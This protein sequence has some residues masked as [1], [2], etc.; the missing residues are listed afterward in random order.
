M[1]GIGGA[2]R[3]AKAR[4]QEFSLEAMEPRLLLSADTTLISTEIQQ[5]TTDGLTSLLGFADTIAAA[6]ALQVKIPGID[7]SLSDIIDLRATLED[8]LVQPVL[9]Y[10]NTHS[11]PNTTFGGLSNALSPFVTLQ[12]WD[13][14]TGDYQFKLDLNAAATTL[15]YN[16]GDNDPGGF[17]LQVNGALGLGVEL[18][19]LV[20]GVKLS[21]GGPGFY[22]GTDPLQ[23]TAEA[24]SNNLD[25][26][27]HLGFLSVGVE[28][29]TIDLNAA[30]QVNLTGLDSNHD[31]M[32]TPAEISANVSPLDVQR[33]G[34][35]DAGSLPI[36]VAL[37]GV[38]SAAGTV[39]LG[40]TDVFDADTYSFDYSGIDQDALNF[41]NIDAAGVV[42]LIG[43][44]S[45]ELNNLR[46]SDFFDQIN[47]PL[48]DGSIGEVLDF[49]GVVSRTLLYDNGAD[50]VK[51]GANR[52]ASDLNAALGTAGLDT[53]IVV[54]G[55]GTSLT[56]QIID[57]TVTSFKIEQVAGN[58]TEL[59]FVLNDAD[60]LATV[61][62][63]TPTDGVIAGDVKMRFTLMR[64]AVSEAVEVTVA[65]D[66]T[67]GN[68]GIG[69]DTI[70]LLRADNS[71]TFDTIQELAFRLNTILGAGSSVVYDP[72]S[73]ALTINLGA[74]LPR[75]DFD[76]DLPIAF[77]F[78]LGPLL[79]I[80]SNTLVNVN[81]SIGFADGFTLGF[82]LGDTVPGAQAGLSTGTPL[83]GLNDGDGVDIK[84]AP[85]LTAPSAVIS[86]MRPLSGDA[87]FEI[88]LGNEASGAA[89]AISAAGT[90]LT[91][92]APGHSFTGKVSVGDTVFNI[93]DG[94][95]AKVISITATTITTGA[96][97][98]G[99]E[100]DWDV[101]D[102]YRT[103]HVVTVG[104]GDTQV[105]DLVDTINEAIDS[106]AALNGR[107]EAVAN[108]NRLSLEAV[109]IAVVGFGF[110]AAQADP[111]VK[112][113]GFYA[114]RGST[115][116]LVG[117]S[118]DTFV[119][120]AGDAHFT[121]T[122][123]GTDYHVTVLQ[124]ATV[125][126]TTIGNLAADVN[127]ALLAAGVGTKVA[128]G[129][130]GT[131]LVLRITD[132]SVDD[133]AFT[134]AI[135]DPAVL[136]LGLTNATTITQ[137]RLGAAKDLTQ[138][139]GRLP[140]DAT[141]TITTTGGL[142]GT[143][144]LF[145]DDTA[146]NSTIL[147]VVSDL[148]KA[149]S[150]ATLKTGVLASF[151]PVGPISFDVAVNGAAP[152]TV[153]LGASALTGNANLSDLVED[154]NAALEAA[155]LGGV[156]TA[157]SS[158]SDSALGHARV[159]FE[160]D[161]ATVLQ[162]QITASAG[163]GLALPT[164]ATATN[165]SGQLVA[166]SAGNKLVLSAVAG[167]GIT[168]FTVA[169]DTGAQA[170]GL[171]AGPQ[172]S[173]SDDIEIRVSNPT[174]AGQVIRVSLDGV[175][176]IAGVI[177]AI[178]TATAG[179]VQVEINEAQTGLTL[180]DTT[181]LANGPNARAFMV[182]A[183]NG[184]GAAAGLRIAG[185]DAI[186]E[187]Q[188][189]GK[190]DGGQLTGIKL[191]DRFF[192]RD[193][194]LVGSLEVSTPGGIDASG[195]VGFVGIN[196]A[197]DASLSADFSI[198]V[199]DPGT[200]AGADNSISLTEFTTGLSHVNTLLDAPSLTGLVQLHLDV[201]LDGSLPFI[202]LGAGTVDLAA[203]LGDA[204]AKWDDVVNL[205]GVT[206][207]PVDDTHFTLSGDL[208][209][210]F[211]R[212]A[213]VTVG[214]FETF[215]GGVSFSGGLT[216]VEVLDDL[217][218][219]LAGLSIGTPNAAISDFESD[220][221]NL[222]EF[223]NV[224]FD[225]DSIVDALLMVRNL[226]GEI[227]VADSLLSAPIPLVDV[228]VSDLLDFADTFSHA[229][230][231]AQHNPAASLQLL[232]KTISEAFG[233]DPAGDLI[234][235]TLDDFGTPGNVDDDVI[236]IELNLG[237]AFGRSLS[238]RIPDLDLPTGVVD[239]GGAATLDAHGSANF[240]L[241]IGIGLNDPSMLY[242]YDSSGLQANL[243]LSGSDM[244]FKA[245]LGP[246]SL[247]V[248]GGSAS[249][250]GTVNASFAAGHFTNGRSLVQ[251]LADLQSLLGD[252]DVDFSAPVSATLPI[253]FPTET[254][255]VGDIT[256]TG[257]LQDLAN[258]L[259]LKTD[260]AAAPAD[261]IVLDVSDVL[262]DL[263]DGFQ[264]L[265]LL[266]QIMFIVDGVDVALG[267]VQDAMDGEMF[268]FTLPII[269]DKLGRAADVVGD[270][271]T[272]FLND[273][274][275][276][277][278]KLADPSENGIKDILFK[279]L[280][281]SGFLIA[282][283][284]DGNAL[285]D[286]DGKFVAGTEDDIQSYNNLGDVS[287]I[288]DAEIWWKVKIGQNL[289]DTGADIGFD[290]GI[291][292]LGLETDGEIK[293]NIDWEL[294]LGFGL[295]GKDGFFFFLDDGHGNPELQLRASVTLPD[296]SLKGTLGFL[297]FT[298]ENKDVDGDG[299]E[300]HLTANFGIDIVN[301][302]DPNDTR[303]GLSELGRM[304]F[305]V[306]F[307]ADASAELGM[308]LGIAGDDG[309]FP[310]LKADFLFD[311]GID[312]INLFDPGDNF[313]FGSAIMDGL[314]VVEFKNVGL[315]VG[316]Y[317][318]NV[319]EPLVEKIQDVTE[320]VQ[321][322]I[323]IVTTP[324]PV[325]SDLGLDIT[326][327][328]IAKASGSVDPRFIDAV[329]TIFDI[330]SMLNSIDLS[331]G[332]SL[333][334]PFGDFTVYDSS[335]PLFANFGGNLGSVDFDL[336]GFAASVLDPNGPLHGLISGLPA[337]LQEVLGEAGGVAAEILGGMAQGAGGGTSDPFK[338]DILED[339]S[340]VFG[341]LMGKPATLISYDM[342]KLSF[343]AEF[344][345]FFSIFGPLGV[346]INLEANLNIDFAFG[347]DTQGFIDFAASDFKN[348]LLLANGLFINDDPTPSDPSDG[349]D[350]P[351]LTF[352]GGLWAAAELNLGIARGG[353]GGGIFIDVDFNLFDNDGD[354][355]IRLDELAT[356][357]SN[358]LKAPDVA[359]RFLAPL[360]IF[361]VSGKVTAELFA[362]LK[363]DFGFFELD[364]K[365]QITPP[366]VLADF[367]V[368]FFRPPV[369]ASEL[370]N[371]DLIINIGDFAG[372]RKLGDLSDFGEHITVEA[373]ADPNVVAIWSDNLE[374]AG[375]DAKQYYH[376]TGKI[377]AI[378]GKGDDIID[379]SGVGSSI[380]Y[381]IDGGIGSD[382]IHGS[383]GGG[384]MRGG[385]GDDFLYGGDGA[386]L[387]L[388]NEGGDT[389]AGGKG[390]DI[391][392]GDNGEITDGLIDMATRHGFVRALVSLTDG[393]DTIQGNEGDDIIAGSGAADTLLDGGADNDVVVGDGALFTYNSPV[394]VSGTESGQGYA[395]VLISGG[396]GNDWLYGGKGDDTIHGDSGDD[397]VFGG[398]GKDAIDGGADK[399]TLFG[400]FGTFI[401]GDLAKPV[402]TVGGDADTI[403]GGLGNDN[404]LGGGGNDVMHGD[405]DNDV[406]WG[407]T[408]AD[409][410]YGDA[411][412]DTIL[413][414]SDQDK[415]YGGSG[416][417]ILEGG[418]GND[419]LFGGD[420]VVGKHDGVA[421]ASDG[422]DTLVAGYGSDV[423]D[424]EAD[425]DFYLINARGGNTTELT[426][427]YDS[428]GGTSDSDLL[429]VTGTGEADVFLLRA[430]SDSYF[431]LE[432]KL[433]AALDKAFIKADL[434]DT[435]L[436]KHELFKDAITA[437]YGPHQAPAT[438]LAALDA[439]NLTTGPGYTKTDVL[440]ALKLAVSS[441]Y[442]SELTALGA[443]HNT[444]FVA[445]LNNGGA[446]VERFNYRS[447]EG[448]V[449]NTVGGDDYVVC[450]DVLGATTINLGTGNDRIQIGQVFHSERIVDNPI[451]GLTT[452]IAPDDVFATIAITRGWLSNGVSVATTVNGGDGNDE[453]TV[454]HNIGALN[455]NGGEG[456]DLF[457]VRAFALAGST[458]SERG[459]TDMKGDAGAD[460]IL[461]AVNAPVG[462]DGGDGFDTVRVIGTEFSD[463]FVVTD[464]G[465]FGAGLNISYVNIEK[466][467]ADG[468]EGNDRFFVLSTGIGVI[469]ELDGGL[470]SDSFFVG[471]SPSD[472][473]IPVISDDLKG[474]SG[475]V[476]HSVESGDLSYAGLA[477][478]GVSA[479]VADNEKD[480]IVVSE[481]GGVSRV[482]E[483]ATSGGEGWQ[484][485]SY[486]V[487]LTRAPDPGTVVKINVVQAALPP[488]DEAKGYRY[489]EFY[490]PANPSN[491]LLDAAGNPIGPVLTFDATNWFTPQTVKFRAAQDVG[492][493]GTAYTFINHTMSDETT[494]PLYADAKVLSVKVQIND[495]DRAGVII[496]PTNRNNTVLEGGFGDTYQVVLTRAPTDDVT[497]HL[498]TINNQVS[499][500]ATTLTFSADPSAPNAWNKPQTVTITAI[501]DNVLE[502]FH[503]DYISYS[504]TSEHDV[505]QYLQQPLY[506]IDG[507]LLTDVFGDGLADDFAPTKPV[508]YMFLAARPVQNDAAKPI[509]I[510]YDADGDLGAGTAVELQ[511]YHGETDGELRYAITGNTLEFYR[512]G[513]AAS[514]SGAI[515]AGYYYLKPGYDQLV[516]QDSVVDI[517]DNDAP[518]VIVTQSD[519]STDVI[520]GG[521]TDSYT[522][523]LSK[524]PTASVTLTIDAVNTRTTLDGFA[525]FQEQV[526]V[527][528]DGFTWAS[529]VQVTFDNDSGQPDSWNAP[530][531]I[532]VRAIDD[533]VLDGDDT[534]VFAPEL[535]TVNKIRG[536]LIIEGAAGSGSL[537]LPAPLMLPGELNV[538]P[539][540]G[541]V[542]AFTPGSGEGAFEYMD[543]KTAELQ[544]LFGDLSKDFNNDGIADFNTFVD[545]ID[546]TLELT[547]GPGTGVVLDPSR[548]RD[549]FDRFWLIKAVDTIAGDPAHMRLKLQNPS[550]VDP[551]SPSVTAPSVLSKY[552]IT[553]LSPNFFADEREQVDFTTVF[554]EDSVADD[555]GRLTSADGNV[556]GYDAAANT[557]TV[558]TADLQALAKL[559][560]IPNLETGLVGRTLQVTVGPGLDRV[561]TIDGV[562]DGAAG[563]KIL[564]LTNVSGSGTPTDR[565]EYRIEGGDRKGR[566]TG[567][568]MGPNLIIGDG[569]Q[570]GGITY[571][572]MEVVQVNLGSGD[573]T[574]TVN[575]ATH[576]DDHT[577]K[578]NGDFYTLTMLNTGEG[579]DHVTVKLID[580]QAG[581]FSLDTGA[582]NDTVDGSASS[583]PLVIF[584]GAGDDTITGGSGADTLFGD[585]GRVDYLDDAGE[586][587]T[588]LGATVAQ[589]PVNP[590]VAHTVASATATTITDSAANYAVGA[591]VGST[592][593][594]VAS[595]GSA[596][597]RTIVSNTAT[598]ITVDS[599]WTIT[600]VNSSFY[601]V[602]FSAANVSIDGTPRA[603]L[604]DP[605][606]NFETGYGGLVGLIVQ[607][608]S[609]D[610]HVQYRQIIANT[611]TQLTLDKPWDTLPVVVDPS[612]PQLNYFYRVASYPEDQTD[613]TYRGPRVAWSIDTEVGGSDTL[614]GGA[615]AD[616]LI[617]GAGVDHVNGGADND[618]IA[619]DNARFDFDPV[620]G[621][622]GPTQVKLIQ[623]TAPG[624]GGDDVLS[625]DAGADII[626]GG[627]GADTIY[628][629]NA[630]GSN[631]ANDGADI[632]IG[633][634]GLIRFNGGYV[635]ADALGTTIDLIQTTDASFGG[636]DTIYG[637]N[638]NDILIGGTGDD[639]VSGDAGL[640]IILGDQGLF[641]LFGGKVTYV[642]DPG[643]AGDDF[644]T[645]GAGVDLI[646][647][648]LGNDRI[649]GLGGAD[650]LIGDEGEAFYAL[651]GVTIVGI[652]TLSL[653]P[654]SGGAD[655]IYGGSEDDIIIG[656]ANSD[657]LDGGDQKDLMFG[658]NVSLVLNAGSG[659]AIDPRFRAL[660]GTLIYGPD[661]L[662]QVAGA[663]VA[664]VQPVPGGR[665]AWGDWTITLDPTLVASRFGD[666]Y[667]AGGS[668]DDEIFGQL[669]NDTIQGDGTIGALSGL[670]PSTFVLPPMDFAL[671]A[672]GT[673]HVSAPTNVGA[674][675]ST[676]LTVQASFEGLN[677]GDDYIEGNGGSDVIF[678]NLGQDDIIGGN[679]SLFSLTTAALRPDGADLLFGGAGID[680]SRNNLGDASL[681]STGATIDTLPT[682]HSRDAD[683]ILGDNGNIF[684]LVGTNGVSSGNY[685]SFN[686]DNY[687]ALSGS[688]NKIIPRAAQLL[689]Y[690]PGGVS[691]DPA[692]ATDI[693]AADEIHGESGDDFIYGMTGSDVLFGEGQDDDLIGGW[694]FD[695]ISGGTGDDGVIGDD[696]R[697]LTSRNGLTEALAGVTVATTESVISTPGNV[698]VATIN[699]TGQ[700]LKAV[701]LTPFAKSLMDPL[702]DPLQADDVIYGGWGNDFLHGGWGDDAM[703]GAEALANFYSQPVNP[704]NVLNYDSATG[705]FALYDEYHPMSYID[706]FLLN[707]SA[708]EGPQLAGK[709]TVSTTDDFF[710]DGDD[711]IFGD[712]GNDWLVGG[713]G[714]DTTYGGWGDDLINADDNQ[715]TVG[716]LNLT[717]DTHA[718]YEDR[719]YGGAGRDVLIG[720]TGGD[721]LI[722]WVGEFNS[723]IVPFA[724]FGTA[725]VSRTL[726]PQLAEFLYALSK[727]D[728]ADQTLGSVGDVRNGEPWAELG[729]V[730]Q[731]DSAWQDQTGAP[732]DPQAGNVP[733]GKRDV[734]RSADFNTG[735]LQGFAADSGIW[736][737]SGGALQVASTS[738]KSDAVAIYQI[739]DALPS[740]YEVLATVKVIKPTG[741]WDANS[742]VVFD[743]QGATSFKYAGID[744]GTNKVVIGERTA[745]GWNVLAQGAITG[746]LKSDAWYNLSLSVNGL[747]ATL[748]VDNKTSL[749]YVFKPTVVDGYSYGLN[750]GLVGFGAN[751]SRGAIDNIAVQ[752][753][754][755]TATV[756][757][758]E[759]FT[760]GAGAMFDTQSSGTWST[761]AG[762][763][764]GAA[765]AGSD[766]ALNLIDL[767]NVT[768]LK[769]TSLLD[770]SAV[771]R[772]AGRAGLV[773]DYYSS[774][775]FKFAAIDVASKQVL[776]GHRTSAGWFIDAAASQSLNATTDYTLG[777]S[778]R[779]SSVSVTINGQAS[780]GFVFNA[781]AADGR[782]GLFTKGATAS[783]DS[784]T[785]KTNDS[786]VPAAQVTTA[787]SATA[788]GVAASLSNEQLLTL[789]AEAVRR[790]ASVEDASLLT[791]L[792]GLEFAVAD[793]PGDQL[794]EF[795]DGKI[796]VDVDAG[797]Y[798]WFVD[799][800]PGDDSEFSGH[801]A[802]LTAKPTG[803][804]AGRIDLL[805]VLAHEIGHA[806][807]F[808]HSESGVMDEERMPGERAL[809]DGWFAA[810]LPSEVIVSD[811]GNSRRET[812]A[813]KLTEL[814]SQIDFAPGL[815]RALNADAASSA[816]TPTTGLVAG[817]PISVPAR[818]PVGQ[819]AGVKAEPSTPHGFDASFVHLASPLA[820]SLDSATV[821]ASSEQASQSVGDEKDTYGNHQARSSSVPVPKS[822]TPV[823]DWQVTSSG[824]LDQRSTASKATSEWL[825]DFLN[826][827]GRTEVQR[828]PN[829]GI[830][831]RPISTG[832]MG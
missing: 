518:T 142:S 53:A 504:V 450:D 201:S 648:G 87:T 425:G 350:P 649:S 27:T 823:I 501:D 502:G 480:F 58:L 597:L 583:L 380:K 328:D 353:V 261:T 404:L 382:T 93:T 407:G 591:L 346:S 817:A 685:L 717:P 257:D 575:Y 408:G 383:N 340:Q 302:D 271:R 822:D 688:T 555:T 476:L 60:D 247:S 668:G 102:Q 83:T 827:L 25:F 599:N 639:N 671:A 349:E 316:S 210:K 721:R 139:V 291:P 627:Q 164:S 485:D 282:V 154:I 167:S 549:L 394:A 831:V 603:V 156:V 612:K 357:F 825:D 393:A 279:L 623:T 337:G 734:L 828:S 526:Q 11:D 379:L 20:F 10:F 683:T 499:L 202:T 814:V 234:S 396:S 733:G 313:E 280:G 699:V 681:N 442:V 600:P 336:S 563:T 820:R 810:G 745:A 23:V 646:I 213:R 290:I 285:K 593:Q 150:V 644:L 253:Y 112:D 266:D 367:D 103:A 47:L 448:L 611:A 530:Q 24:Q 239:F 658:D 617:G 355:K 596:Q 521:L 440:A 570:P 776:I 471:G 330:I 697:I 793:L 800:T 85:A 465:V 117:D 498:T 113:L 568:G 819:A 86:T 670:I 263:T 416:N 560:A 208:T 491:I 13:D 726:Q 55:D 707:F 401:D 713:T 808:G 638:G 546:K 352:D 333:L 702:F 515:R 722:D 12:T 8:N 161:P 169:G 2:G 177:L 310:Q 323:D 238:V 104:K 525:R 275:A 410:L 460:T 754:P 415:L 361:D 429:T 774:T 484:Y 136:E 191:S 628:G 413:G 696:G 59:G 250:A 312:P 188:R 457:T 66:S 176:D 523:Q 19:S 557:M 693:G 531:T 806:I 100:N 613:G 42:T 604:T 635:G 232:D 244:A 624:T 223:D 614:N 132:A 322:I 656:G 251:D 566:I 536:P 82:Y 803:E 520:E 573:D 508:S 127:A 196:L 122:I 88:V 319:V 119:L 300:T 304:G 551:A 675:R 369:L 70:K 655:A 561:W 576:S 344:S 358:Q 594:V 772:T 622:D 36:S 343:E 565:S 64:G 403:F 524:Q 365:F 581:A 315:D 317:I 268:G 760:T 727:S 607:A 771:L 356:N 44:L 277:V 68:T 212:G 78:D 729:V 786:A 46:S 189:D 96:L 225:F 516:V 572:D 487:R 218:V 418:H 461:Y 348:P 602:L 633:D 3:P 162:L 9:D 84:T 652:D 65:A 780:V 5:A 813:I 90:L 231:E 235:F 168:G 490:D 199:N 432:A 647:G 643:T 372:E 773:F 360:A 704:G 229:L 620:S 782:F 775:D 173:D 654:G 178:E 578:R 750:W 763:L 640:D 712:H 131:S 278:E 483:G 368:D 500:S 698:Q 678:G 554:D 826:H 62:T 179:Q 455:L 758:R 547:Q 373:T 695:W 17:G 630:A 629:D 784:V 399:D 797:G 260:A 22:L 31:Q 157:K 674:S 493:E 192:M 211:V 226:L 123:G 540:D 544:S 114:T 541:D 659:D 366:A 126:N 18:P 832:A 798:G 625:G 731:Q 796:T 281:D 472:A 433:T 144:T 206:V 509:V 303:L 108:G 730:R 663:F 666:D 587:V 706:G 830:R 28:N 550:A 710:T 378:G 221:G 535:H 170:L 242:L 4:R 388:G 458:D 711:R 16:L 553:N 95:S 35:L 71:A 14:V 354:G 362:F 556:L 224:D 115:G 676:T 228:S 779:G 767:S 194:S 345:A 768:N 468:A 719:A 642:K 744:I 636:N 205:A 466:L 101:G 687:N 306:L 385:A 661:G 601:R 436:K 245:A 794:A 506:K 736:Q 766:T 788:D 318:T 69:D 805:S 653:N 609:P 514:I 1:R 248:I 673:L 26:G 137:A 293:L 89:T 451:I 327:L 738:T 585:I 463:D 203:N 273:F 184:S 720:N 732:R 267:G 270:F 324:L 590:P 130:S 439:V 214:S 792:S 821:V 286:G 618:S 63:A 631:G 49:G 185:I 155:G 180:I 441:H 708:T 562:T 452:H 107:I 308:T 329:E 743:Y 626:F 751:K 564:A 57:P 128:V 67:T 584:G 548:P 454:F 227:E 474:H 309:G 538:R 438:M 680:I 456:D 38:A 619:G 781:V 301:D 204:L 376:V 347:Y 307:S 691:F 45:D 728:G 765:P 143:L 589:S 124:S 106:L 287:D 230:T 701:D 669:G 292:G 375:S 804:A 21:G 533:G 494:D 272:G 444:A 807:G 801:G 269:G 662:A 528:L 54:Q 519:G 76:D 265:S 431:P 690:T 389:I 534:Q 469:T 294:N 430:M 787:L 684:R 703:S 446:N 371:G 473:P 657:R 374:D 445:L 6:P 606:G 342:P 634:N 434:L 207:T 746:S 321:P 660:T 552:A 390:A 769:T 475:I 297:E 421:G 262:N 497:V 579:D 332:G 105:A 496:T 783:F 700:L 276:E 364:K 791:G 186:D 422:V 486:T 288:A 790:W 616:M 522:V 152:K 200:G 709:G 37:T 159:K 398:S 580:G 716:S 505:D 259:F 481:S 97:Q 98:G 120:T 479:N 121:L 558:E 543:V 595:D 258:G 420:G 29:G 72:T 689:D 43:R 163:N 331:S 405:D 40:A 477:V 632:V 650:I 679:S 33:S 243:D 742:Y 426:T 761:S 449:L 503:T 409:T 181:Y 153:T 818:E 74:L 414:E 172:A 217:P 741:G 427:A 694:G 148:N 295:S 160:G 240:K 274:R 795:A 462:I 723:Y 400:D 289:L 453:F 233:V 645:G 254:H 384:V 459:R 283:D 246:L 759:D 174:V 532:Y 406:L 110:V 116:P 412:N 714:R 402:V 339:P 527:S 171:A 158:G 256:L 737:T 61:H 34:T 135:D 756:T 641:Q 824:L 651:D 829:S 386:D 56:F 724:P 81:A 138:Y 747:T 381:E 811:G 219:S 183:A 718:S 165:F 359:D 437:A 298:A 785:A 255:L 615:G 809:P 621:N 166:D 147:S 435:D 752:V 193:A 424:G 489:L 284:Q 588:R 325:L 569:V 577:T 467:V 75:L 133:V 198:G 757:Y 582:G 334:V 92:T 151:A 816:N 740:Y 764:T 145:A 470:G 492:S 672:G 341:M 187:A 370:D 15:Q 682:G 482:T 296:A 141:L 80:Q 517:Y 739:G 241:D 423:L 559:L 428:G 140:A 190:I 397:V 392:L 537:S 320:P 222:V 195:H 529:A 512:N 305:N 118:L 637:N 7:K 545:L 197:G 134:A 326:L 91:D 391:L 314:K 377:I 387:I 705:E 111:A 175:T 411:G 815:L 598:V 488:E 52:L 571:G 39:T 125:G 182:S 149:L 216:T 252:I 567:F 129:A 32:L 510:M 209:D 30:V 802:T 799:P 665:P 749:S 264:N 667:I 41:G 755:L 419:I 812:A 236:K 51:D 511:K 715:G 592:I 664:T 777:V 725:T 48:V 109:D 762:R 50:G 677:D 692:A 748:T 215:V 73:E 443:D 542:V 789:A 513:N 94:S 507:D 610:G 778:V 605:L 770:L 608:I 478:D 77:D 447:I 753:V 249:I 539:S 735:E 395:D 586:I 495:D 417:D 351:E 335:S 574:V 464:A 686:Y 363:I 146:S 237:A 220:L 99:T 311:W 79:G 338:F 299:D